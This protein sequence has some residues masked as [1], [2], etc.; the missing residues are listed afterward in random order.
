MNRVVYAAEEEE[1]VE[2]ALNTMRKHKVRRL[3]VMNLQ[4]QLE[5]ILS[6][7][8]IVLKA[9]ESGGKT[10]KIGYADVVKTYAGICERKLPVAKPAA[11]K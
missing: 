9:T 7:D 10:P 3:P 8:D 4:G 2:Q 1:D 5:G 6:L 11:A